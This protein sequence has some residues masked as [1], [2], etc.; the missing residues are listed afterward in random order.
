M[1]GGWQLPLHLPPALSVVPGVYGGSQVLDLS[2][3]PLVTFIGLTVPSF[4]SEG[5]D[6]VSWGSVAG[7]ERQAPHL[8]PGGHLVPSG[9]IGLSA[10]PDDLPVVGDDLGVGV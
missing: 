8:Q 6:G 5:L 7:A 9:L 2:P 4:G 3:L 10:W 1:G